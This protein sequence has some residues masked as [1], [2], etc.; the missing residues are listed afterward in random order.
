MMSR[1]LNRSQWGVVGGHGIKFRI[2]KGVFEIDGFQVFVDFVEDLLK[3]MKKPTHSVSFRKASCLLLTLLGGNA[4]SNGATLGF[5][6]NLRYLSFR[7]PHHSI[8]GP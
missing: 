1:S 4:I 7:L 3:N 2:E 8:L 6:I 5:D